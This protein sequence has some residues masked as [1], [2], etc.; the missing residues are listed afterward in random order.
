MRLNGADLASFDYDLNGKPKSADFS[1]GEVSEGVVLDYDE[2]TRRF[3]RHSQTAARFN[4][5]Y[6]THMNRRGL[7]AYDIINIDALN[8][9]RH[10][11]NFFR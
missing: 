10:G 3:V 1:R 7:V 4:A 11:G 9:E 2:L 8:L 5:A 6:E